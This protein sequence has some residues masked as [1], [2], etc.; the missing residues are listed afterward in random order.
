MAVLA[1][2]PLERDAFGPSGLSAKRPQVAD[3]R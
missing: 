1:G 2:E 3:S